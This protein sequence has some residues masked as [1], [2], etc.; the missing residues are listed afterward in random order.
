MDETYHL[1]RIER[2]MPDRA[3]QLSVLRGQK[4]LTLAMCKDGRPYVV[5]LNYAFSEG[6]NCFY[7][8]SAPEGRKV[9]YLTANPLV[10]GMVIEDL[11]YAVGECSHKYSI[12][13]VRG[14]G[15]VHHGNRREAPRAGPHD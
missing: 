15:G 11:G 4:F 9:D 10:S 2:D 13:H 12:G 3:D 14:D 6:E 5:A 8:H 7:L 1:R